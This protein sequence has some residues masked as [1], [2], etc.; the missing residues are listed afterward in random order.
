MWLLLVHHAGF[1]RDYFF[2]QFRTLRST[3]ALPSAGDVLVRTLGQAPVVE[4]LIISPTDEV[5]PTATVTRL[6]DS[7]LLSILRTGTASV[8]GH[9][10]VLALRQAL[11]VVGEPILSTNLVEH[12]PTAAFF[13]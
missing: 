5:D 11:V 6:R 9:L 12:S 3:G 2:N 13:T 4:G 8:T 1:N 10:L 7:G